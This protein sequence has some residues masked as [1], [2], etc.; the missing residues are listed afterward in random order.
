MTLVLSFAIL[1]AF[2]W[3]AFKYF[4]AF[5]ALEDSFPP[6]WRDSITA[7]FALA[8]VALNPSTPLPIQADYVA[9]LAGGC[10]AVLFIT[11]L[12]F[13]V[14]ETRG[15]W[16]FFAIFA[17]CVASTIKSAMKYFR[18]RKHGVAARE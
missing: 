8:S 15:G 9:S 18:N 2:G 5:S 17:V 4:S 13:S 16:L 6:E 7:R 12:A 11:L 3:S 14:G 1:A 10:L